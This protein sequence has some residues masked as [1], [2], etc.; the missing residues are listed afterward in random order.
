M[1]SYDDHLPGLDA[2][3]EC[4]LEA[5]VWALLDGPRGHSVLVPEN[6][7]RAGIDCLRL[8]ASGGAACSEAAMQVANT[9]NRLLPV[10]AEQSDS[11]WFSL[12]PRPAEVG[13]TAI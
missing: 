3:P 10:I 6:V 11:P 8:L 7:L 13:K 2:L 5:H 12:A 9:V 4:E 1:A